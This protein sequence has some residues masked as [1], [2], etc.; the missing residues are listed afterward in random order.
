MAKDWLVQIQR[1]DQQ[2]VMAVQALRGKNDVVDQVARWIGTYG[3]HLFFL[4]M[5]TILV[6]Y[7]MMLQQGAALHAAYEIF[8][9]IASALSTK[10]VID[11]I[12]THVGRV[13]PFVTEG[14]TPLIYKDPHDPS[15][16]S[17]HAGGAFALGTI[18]AL[19]FPQVLVISLG[20][21]FLIAFARFYIGLHYI[22]DVVVGAMIGCSMSFLY[23]KIWG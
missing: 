13:R 20:L 12:A 5:G 14:F 2:W 23:W 22:T 21:A 15:F 8:V 9:A 1:R 16:P 3:P 17:N 6:A 4:E 18:L 11:P 10:F 19:T 7:I